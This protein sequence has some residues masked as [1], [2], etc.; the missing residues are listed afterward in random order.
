M[1]SKVIAL[2]TLLSTIACGIEYPSVSYKPGSFPEID[3]IV[4]EMMNNNNGSAAQLTITKNGTVFYDKAFGYKEKESKKLMDSSVMMRLGSVSK[5]LTVSII[6]DLLSKKKIKITDQP[7]RKWSDLGGLKNVNTDLKDITV[8]M[9]LKHSG[10]WDR[11]KSFD[12]AFGLP[13][14]LLGNRNFIDLNAREL[15]SIMSVNPLEFKPGAEN[16]YS[17]FGYIVLGRIIEEA[18]GVD[19]A[20]Y[21][22]KFMKKEI[23]NANF[24]VGRSSSKI[25]NGSPECEYN[26]IDCNMSVMDA[27]GGCI[28]NTNALC[29]FLDTFL[30]SGERWNGGSFTYTF[31]GSIPGSCSFVRQRPDRIHYAYIQN[32]RSGPMDTYVARIDGIL[33]SYVTRNKIK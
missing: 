25:T 16:C 27:A 10:G 11:N 3:A 26:D 30:I 4:Q 31:Y 8:E 5:P 28:S 9:L 2:L 24:G 12:P 6:H 20:N 15:V 21:L 18:T 14:K 23:R 33:D 19:Y 17:N 32:G 1:N 22:S 7:F 29:L 13:E